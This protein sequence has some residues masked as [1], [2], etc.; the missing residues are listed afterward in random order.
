MVGVSLTVSH[1]EFRVNL[2]MVTIRYRSWYHSDSDSSWPWFFLGFFGLYCL[3]PISVR[4]D[5]RYWLI[6]LLISGLGPG[7]ANGGQDTYRLLQY[8][9][10]L[11]RLEILIRHRHFLYGN[12]NFLRVYEN[13][14]FLYKNLR[15]SL[16]KSEWFSLW[17]SWWCIKSLTTKLEFLWLFIQTGPQKPL[18]FDILLSWKIRV[19]TGGVETRWLGWQFVNGW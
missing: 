4:W 8:I 17:F 3:N 12:L 7:P 2:I 13:L 19:P 16:W 15:F 14:N 6:P 18:P 11:R 1:L 5:P 9:L 10:V